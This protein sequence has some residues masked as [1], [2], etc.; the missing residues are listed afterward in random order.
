VVEAL[1]A[2]VNSYIMKP[3]TPQELK[4]KIE[5]ILKTVPVVAV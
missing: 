5:G 1:Q 4:E 2:K 3:F